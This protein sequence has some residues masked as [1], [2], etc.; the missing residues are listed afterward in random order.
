ML[1]ARV[2]S[3]RSCRL[4]H[5]VGLH[6]SL[7]AGQAGFYAGGRMAEVRVVCLHASVS[8]DTAG[9]S[10]ESSVVIAAAVGCVV[11]SCSTASGMCCEFLRCTP[12]EQG[13]AR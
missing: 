7:F 3:N 4:L 13:L 10:E 5:I 12:S 9:R 8:A 11:G 6:L 1:A 2:G